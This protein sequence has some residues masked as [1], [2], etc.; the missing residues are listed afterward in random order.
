MAELNGSRRSQPTTSADADFDSAERFA[1]VPTRD[2]YLQFS[3]RLIEQRLVARKVMKAPPKKSALEGPV[4][5]ASNT[6]VQNE[7]LNEMQ[8]ERVGDSVVEDESRYEVTL[9]RADGK[10]S[11]VVMDRDPVALL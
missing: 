8:R 2:G 3:S 9:R 10:E 7:I 11:I 4:N 1:L 6:E 5:M